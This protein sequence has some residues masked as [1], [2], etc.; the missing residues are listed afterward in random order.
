MEDKKIINKI[1][2]NLE[3]IQKVINKSD[4]EEADLEILVDKKPSIIQIRP[5]VEKIMA[6]FTKTKK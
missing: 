5:P 1:I 4:I 6:R 3:D 2:K